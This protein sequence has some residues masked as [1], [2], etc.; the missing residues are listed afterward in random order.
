MTDHRKPPTLLSERGLTLADLRLE[1]SEVRHNNDSARPADVF[2][3]SAAAALDR[4]NGQ[5]SR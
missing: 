2:V 5:A 4:L 1:Q 3:R